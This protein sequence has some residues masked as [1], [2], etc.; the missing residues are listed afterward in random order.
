M[1]SPFRLLLLGH[2]A[3]TTASAE[4][5]ELLGH[6]VDESGKPIAC[7]V[8]IESTAG[9]FFLAEGTNGSRHAHYNRDRGKSIEVHT[10]LDKGSFKATLPEG[11][12]LITVE[13]GKE[14]FPTRKE[15]TIGPVPVMATLTLKRWVN[16]SKQGWFSGDTHVH[17]P[18]NT[19]PT[20][21]S[22]E[23]LNLAFPMTGW[24]RNAYD[25]PA[26]TYADGNQAIA[27]EVIRIDD[28]HLIY[29]L[30]TEWEIFTVDRKRHTLGAIFAIGHKKPFTLGAP[31]VKP[32]AE[33]ARR[34]GALL[35]LDKHNWPWSMMLL[36][37]A[38]VDLFELT[39]NHV[40]QTHFM[41]KSWYP[42]YTAPYM[43]VPKDEDGNFASERAWLEFG[44]RNYYTLLNC[45]FPMRPTGGTASGVHP[46]PVGFGR[47][48]V[49]CPDG[50]S[51]EN[52]LHHLNAGR[53]FVT[54]GPMLKVK[55]NRRPAGTKLRFDSSIPRM[56][57]LTGQV[58]SKHPIDTIEIIVNGRVARWWRPDQSGRT[59]DSAYE[60]EIDIEQP[61]STSGWIAVRVFSQLPNG[62]SRF[63]HSSPV[64]I[65]IDG[66]PL[67]PRR[68][69]TQYLVK[70]VEDELKRHR[71]ILNAEAIAEFEEALA[72][73]RKIDADSGDNTPHLDIRIPGLSPVRSP[74]K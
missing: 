27:T 28:T 15:I 3:F 52:W 40:W 68:V 61:L 46:V 74:V 37:I 67:R 45:G 7:R 65:D 49:E 18:L 11:R 35:E 30:N 24:V 56:I 25:S 16:M 10:A 31:P 62:R 64:H 4:S 14:Y 6:I 60:A 70:R 42:K 21:V 58:L 17:L 54:T 53:S 51:Y 71:G 33:E 55:A 2:L 22:A 26:G 41:F 47:V 5:A 34:Q 43:N 66:R 32:L 8:Y 50:F 39:N 20:F 19:L 9:G 57:R 36:P 29:P 73:Y 48:Y 44:F 12:Y 63:A 38:D 59:A 13:R 69:E 1:K 72:V 23:D